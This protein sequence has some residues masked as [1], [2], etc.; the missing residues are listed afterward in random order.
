VTCAG[1]KL[2]SEL[3]EPRGSALLV[4]THPAFLRGAWDV[5]RVIAVV[6]LVAVLVGLG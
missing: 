3:D 1:E 6:V 4:I 2:R 5:A